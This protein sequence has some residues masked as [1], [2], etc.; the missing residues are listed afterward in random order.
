MPHSV[1]VAY[2]PALAVCATRSVIYVVQHITLLAGVSCLFELEALKG[3]MH[4]RGV[5]G[6]P[7][8]PLD[9]SF[10]ACDR[11]WITLAFAVCQRVA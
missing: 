7:G 9:A 3:T 5:S 1:P 2:N 4:S 10:S 8:G 6:L 11:V